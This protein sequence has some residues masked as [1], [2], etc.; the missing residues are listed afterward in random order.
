[1]RKGGDPFP[2][3]TR[4]EN[5]LDKPEK[6]IILND[7]NGARGG[8]EMITAET[9]STRRKGMRRKFFLMSN[10]F[11][12]ALRASAVKIRELRLRE[13]IQL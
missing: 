6:G 11:L 4:I 13:N 2:G 12:C 9:Q 5:N 7:D 3:R 1:M 8:H 10:Q